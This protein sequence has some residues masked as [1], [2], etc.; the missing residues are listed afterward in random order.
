MTLPTSSTSWIWK[1]L[2]FSCGDKTTEV[3]IEL[4]YNWLQQLPD[5]SDLTKVSNLIWL[6]L[7]R[8]PPIVQVSAKSMEA[9]SQARPYL[10][11]F[12]PAQ[13]RCIKACTIRKRNLKHINKDVNQQC[14]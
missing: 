10:T 8:A 14:Q 12:N 3:Y 6:S 13:H 9:C 1:G 11:S 7:S 5:N 2:A 4:F